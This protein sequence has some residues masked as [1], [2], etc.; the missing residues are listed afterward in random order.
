VADYLA[1]KESEGLKPKTIV[2][3]TEWLADSFVPFAEG[4]AGAALDEVSPR[5]FEAYANLRRKT[6]KPKS[7]YT[8]LTIVKQFLKWCSGH[9]RDYLPRNPVAGCRVRQPYVPP[10]FTPTPEQVRAI[11]DAAGGDRKRQYA[12][13][14]FAGLRADE[15]TTLAPRAV[16][17]KGG[18]VHV[19]GRDGWTPKT[20]QARKIPIHPILL[21][22]LAGVPAAPRPYFFCAPACP[23]YP[24]GQHHINYRNMN[25]ALQ[26][27][28]APLGI[29]VGRKHDG[30]VYH[31]LRH[32]FETACVDSGIP[33]FVIDV[34]MG[35]VG[36]GKS[37]GKQ[38]YGFSESKSRAYMRRVNFF[39]TPEGEGEQLK[40]DE[41]NNS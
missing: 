29:P 3:Y 28:A 36:K 35:H 26:R 9:G 24:D 6:Q 32:F 40:S 20:M 41:R 25:E 12:L 8:G 1:C 7:L 18:W 15:V 17:L 16:D 31:S 39:P 19:V 21:D 11:L 34:W 5:L 13:A 33:Q 38:Y 22:L 2:K 10:Q 4:Q 14:A 30:L 23:R 27:L 37:M